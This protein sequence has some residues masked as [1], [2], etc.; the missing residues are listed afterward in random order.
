MHRVTVIM[1]ILVVWLSHGAMAGSDSDDTVKSNG[2]KGITVDDLGRALRSAG[3]NIEKEIP[4]I[5]PAIGETFKNITG[6]GSEKHSSQQPEKQE[7]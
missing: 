6:K 4:K 1:L 5:G 3:Q 2:G 7:K